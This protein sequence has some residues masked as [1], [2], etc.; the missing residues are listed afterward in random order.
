MSSSHEVFSLT[1]VLE[2]PS[3][4]SPCFVFLIPFEIVHLHKEFQ[5]LHYRIMI[6][7]LQA[8]IK[9]NNSVYAKRIR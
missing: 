7:R 9:E 8:I 1:Q 5:S 3:S 4:L 2:F 6:I